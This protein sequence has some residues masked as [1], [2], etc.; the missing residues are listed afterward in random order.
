MARI[1]VHTLVA[2]SDAQAK[3][4]P[5]WQQWLEDE[6]ASSILLTCSESLINVATVPVWHYKREL[7]LNEHVCFC[8]KAQGPVL[9]ML[10]DLFL[11]ALHRKIAPFRT[12]V[13][14]TTEPLDEISMRRALQLD[15]FLGDR[16]E[17][18]ATGGSTDKS[19]R[20][21]HS[22]LSFS[23]TPEDVINFKDNS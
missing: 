13:V 22:C 14:H 16:F 21:S 18:G 8:C 10:R 17:Y 7:S 1:K 5:L 9:S 11:Q 19:N 6:A 2:T 15:P 3:A 20:L 23:A 4:D 12:V